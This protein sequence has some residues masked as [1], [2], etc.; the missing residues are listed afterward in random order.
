MSIRLPLVAALLGV[1]AIQ[2]SATCLAGFTDVTD[3]AGLGGINTA[4]GVSVV[5]ENGDGCADVMYT[6]D[7]GVQLFR[8]NCDGTFSNVTAAAGLS[9]P[10]GGW[11]AGWADYDADGDLDVYVASNE[12]NDVL[13]RND[14]GSYVDVTV[15][16]GVSNERGSTG[17]AWADYDM[18]GDLD[19]FVSARFG[20]QANNELTDRLYRNNGN[21]TFTDVAIAAGVGDDAFRQTFMG[22]WFDYDNDRDQDLYLSVDFGTDVLFENNG[23][24]TFTDVS[25]FA[26]IGAPEHGMGVSIGDLNAD[27]CMDVFTSNNTTSDAVPEFGPSALYINNCDGTFTNMPSELGLLD[28]SVV[29]WGGNFID[30]DNDGDVDLA[31]VAGGML[32]NG[33]A[34]VLYENY[35]CSGDLLPVTDAQGVADAG[36]SF[37]SAWADYDD[38]GDLDWFVANSGGHGPSRLFRNDGPTGHY[39]I[40]ELQGAAMNPTA[41]GAR[42][43]VTTTGRTQVREIRSGT[44]YISN[45]EQRAHFGL[46]V[47]DSADSVRVLWPTGV[48][49][50]LLDVAGDQ[51]LVVSQDGSGPEPLPGT[52]QGSVFHPDGLPAPQARVRIK[53]TTTNLEVARVITDANGNYS[54]GEL[55]SAR[56]AILAEKSGFRPAAAAIELAEGEIL[57]VNLTLSELLP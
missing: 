21:G 35:S 4:R 40:V 22:V 50:E 14:G 3:A 9:G 43:E 54:V 26:G 56:Y 39:L 57:T 42:V 24:G 5:D 6:T 13:Y 11:T 31:I 41:I 55:A 17:A 8:S 20:T 1:A 2:W 51:V 28:R 19:L 44:S 23:D 12:A 16:A 37:G 10:M 34:N 25:D 32:S 38:D 15:A 30:W 47:K 7:T 18:D 45:E 52:I 53:N 29:E 36:A 46:G 48:T 33:E 27:G 49:T